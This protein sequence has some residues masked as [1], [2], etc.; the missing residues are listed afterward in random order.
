MKL[1]IDEKDEERESKAQSVVRAKKRAGGEGEGGRG[2]LSLF[3]F[4]VDAKLHSHLNCRV[5]LCLGSFF[6]Y[7]LSFEEF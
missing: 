2:A 3:I 4:L 5:S 1:C 6:E 7:Q